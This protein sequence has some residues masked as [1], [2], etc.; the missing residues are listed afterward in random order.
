M[1]HRLA[2]ATALIALLFTASSVAAVTKG[3]VADDGEHPMVG[4][5]VFY[6][7][8][9]LPSIFGPEQPGGWFTCSG[10]LVSPTVVLTAGHCAFAI[11]E[12]S[13]S[14][15]TEE[16]RFTATNEDGTPNG[17]GGNDVWFT[18]NE[19][20]GDD[21]DTEPEHW[22]GWPLNFTPDGDLNFANQA[23]RYAARSGFLNA[24]PL[25]IRATSFPHPS[26]DDRAFYLH[27][28]GVIVL[29]EAQA[30]PY[31]TIAGEDYLQ[32]YA[33][34]RSAHRFEVVGYGLQRSHPVF[35]VDGDTRMKAD[36][37]LLN[38]VS[39]PKDTYI[40]LSNNAHTGG[41]CFG[42]SGGPTFDTTDSLL[43]VAV[44]S[45]GLS[46]NCTGIGGAYRLD[47]PDDL[48]FLA[49]FGITPAD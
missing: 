12:D 37:R 13:A 15:T 30:G 49:D 26:Y 6:V 9:A 31:A 19:G 32:R 48:D 1:R 42:D 46:P 14:T 24:N 20:D 39:N 34:S 2:V 11:G 44:T 18:L 47:Q 40:Q 43:V 33:G 7:P 41:T 16:N 3:G 28:A 5:L 8:D 38:L 10:T 25:W 29:D 27:D 22:E 17:S 36:V 4:Q 35:E 45:F 23:A 21:A